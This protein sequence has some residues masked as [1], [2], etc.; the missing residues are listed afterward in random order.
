MY[1]SHIHVWLCNN[2]LYTYVYQIYSICKHILWKTAQALALSVGWLNVWVL[3]LIDLCRLFNAKSI[4]MKIVL[5]QA[6]PFM[7]STQ[8]KCKNSLIGKKHF[9]FKLFN[10]VKQF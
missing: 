1:V 10:L 3:W 2:N 7:I 6:I 9:Y 4:L 8:F 5:F